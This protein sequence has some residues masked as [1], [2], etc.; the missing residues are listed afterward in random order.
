MHT[1]TN[2]CI[3]IYEY[4]YK[5]TFTVVDTNIRYTRC[6]RVGK[7]NLS[8]RDDLDTLNGRLFNPRT[9]PM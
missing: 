9:V 3:Y 7:E 1:H 2:L 6:R 5:A 8:T 4:K